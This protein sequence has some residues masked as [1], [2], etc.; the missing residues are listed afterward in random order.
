MTATEVQKQA[1][2]PEIL[3]LRGKVAIITGGTTGIGRATALLLGRKG[4]KVVVYGRHPEE[5]EDTLHDMMDAGVAEYH[6]LTADNAY[7]EQIVKVFAECRQRFGEPE[8]LINNAA[9]PAE[10]ILDTD[11]DE[12]LYIL[13]VN[14]LGY[15]TCVREA[16][17]SMR[18][19]GSGHIVN[20]GSMSAVTREAGS[21]L[22]VATK[23]AI[24]AMSESL[25][26]QL[27]QEGIRVSLVEPGLVGTNLH[28]EPADV[29][30]QLQMQAEAKMLEAED[31]AHAIYCVLTQPER[32]N[33]YSLRVG[34]VKQPI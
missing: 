30:S 9:L 14:I 13:R 23:A 31:I 8:I 12:A 32:S 22:Y 27:G 2:E 3:T 25:R 5:L 17:K 26:K 7:E 16:A 29:P 1:Y 28:G 11:Y 21:E 10:S 33:M 18:A 24:A 19:R 34:P 15:L 6:G 4:V 20:V